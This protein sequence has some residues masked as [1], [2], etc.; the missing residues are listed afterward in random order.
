MPYSGGVASEG[1]LRILLHLPIHAPL[2]PQGWAAG[3]SRVLD[4]RG[5]M[6]VQGGRRGLPGRAYTF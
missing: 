5:G 4:D 6:G 3:V 1:D 2:A